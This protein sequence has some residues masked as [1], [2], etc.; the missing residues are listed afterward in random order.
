MSINGAAAAGNGWGYGTCAADGHTRTVQTIPTET[1]RA[2][3]R[4]E[5]RMNALFDQ[6]RAG[7][8]AAAITDR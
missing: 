2:T 6:P 4:R 8:P 1:T 3:R 7:G 5:T